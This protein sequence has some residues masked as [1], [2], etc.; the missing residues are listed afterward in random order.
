MTSHI[1]RLSTVGAVSAAVREAGGQV[2]GYTLELRR[3][4]V[5]H[6]LP[7]LPAA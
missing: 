2:N 1:T 5:L 3:T 7:A 6:F 4:G